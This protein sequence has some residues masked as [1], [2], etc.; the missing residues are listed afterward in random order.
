MDRHEKAVYLTFDDGPIPEATPF[1]LDTLANFGVRAT[2]FMVGDNVRKHP[3]LYRRVV[4]AGIRTP[5]GELRREPC[6]YFFSSMPLKDLV[7]ALRGT[8]VPEDVKRVAEGLPYRDFITVG[9]LV[10]KLEITNETDIKTYAGRV[11]DTW[12]YIQERDVKIGRLQVFNNWSPYL[13][14]DYRGTM[15]IGLEY[16]C[17]EGDELW[18]MSDK[19]FIEMAI[20]E[21]EKIGIVKRSSVRDACRIR[22]RKAYPS[23]FGTYYELDKVKKFLDSI[24]NLYCVGRNGQ[25]R[26]N[27][28]DHSMLT[29]MEAVDNLAAGIRTKENI[30]AV[31]TEEEYHE[32]KSN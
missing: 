27:N 18:T 21:L 11:P 20:G 25:H 32:T 22:I 2:F 10:D 28:M 23:Y 3:D 26:Y 30:W 1:I 29:A 12:I 4:A 9:L 6:D 16:F 24:E 13:V 7:R 31:N 8:E 19:E 5:Q 17:T 14:K 15:W